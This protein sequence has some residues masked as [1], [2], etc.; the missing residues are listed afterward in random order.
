MAK[1]LLTSGDRIQYSVFV[2][3]VKPARMVRLKAELEELIV[4]DEDS[5][6]FCDLGK[7]AGIDSRIFSFLGLDRSIT[8][9]EAII[10]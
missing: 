8:P 2:C 5:I 4:E 6:L 10:L 9:T 3:D 7:V 1:R